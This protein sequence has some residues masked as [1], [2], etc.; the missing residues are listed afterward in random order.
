MSIVSSA[1]Q[2]T[3][4]V[5]DDQIGATGSLQQ[6]GFL[7]NYDALPFHFVFESCEAQGG[8]AV[9]PALAVVAREDD[10]TLVLLDLSFGPDD[11][12]LGLD[13]LQQ[14]TARFPS[15]PVLIMS[16]LE[17]DVD[18][19]G[20][21]LEDGA[22]GFVEKHRTP[23]YLRR[24]IEQAVALMES[25][26]LLGQ[27][28]PLKE[29]RRQAARLS[30]YDQIPVVV[31][32]ERGTGKER[33][34]RYIHQSGPRRQGPFVAVNCAGVPDALFEAEFF[35]AEK[36]AYTGADVQ[37]KGYLERAHGGT[38]FL[39]EV[40]TLPLAMQAKLLRVLQERKFGRLG[41][42][43]EDLSSAFQLISATNSVPEEL[44]ASGQLREDFYD[45][46][47]AVTIHT[48]P[49]RACL[50]DL[51]L[52]A[53]H[54]LQK[55]VGDRKSLAESTLSV[56]MTYQWPGN[57]RELQRVIQEAVVRSEDS[58]VLAIEHLPARLSPTAIAKSP[59][60]VEAP[61]PPGG[62][63]WHRQRLLAELRLAVEA[64]RTIAEYK[65]RQW[66]AEFMRVMYPHAKAQ[67][68]KGFADLI[69]RLT[70][71]PWGDPDAHSDSEMRSLLNELQS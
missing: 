70:S 36:G 27:S 23:E 10:V 14:L 11:L 25:N 6:K 55:L 47:A 29:L 30:P 22:V 67:N 15:L 19:L 43:H 35:G 52:L 58:S 38:L 57:V 44:V 20:R 54:Y 12:L 45:R 71:G 68:A 5:V 64:K 9:E 1:N 24:A 31:L 63:D 41:S 60:A 56:M 50:S 59:E 26:V 32:G 28:A 2:R 69:K 39:D 18:M 46:I 3:I 37:R 49:L 16:A 7:R 48:P 42:S 53:S 66:K 17:R 8:Y 62:K 34:A 13:I 61:E 40:G 33:V 4:L 65:G 21:C 51:P